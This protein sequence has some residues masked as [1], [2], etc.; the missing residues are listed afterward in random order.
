M[1]DTESRK[2][3]QEAREDAAARA[4]SRHH[5]TTELAEREIRLWQARQEGR[6][7]EEK[8]EDREGK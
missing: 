5:T 3:A 7:G 1:S 6:H 2:A 4:A 8:P